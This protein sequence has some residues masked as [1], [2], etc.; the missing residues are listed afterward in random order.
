MA[1]IGRLTA[2]ADI[3]GFHLKGFIAWFAWVVIH[4]LSLSTAKNRLATTW[5]WMV[6]FFTGKQSFRM[7]IEPHED[8]FKMKK[9]SKL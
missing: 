6:A 7:S 2:V 1:M 4:I 5:N 3:N 8:S 9:E